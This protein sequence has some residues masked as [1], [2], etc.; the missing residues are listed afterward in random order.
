MMYEFEEG[1]Q[2]AHE[3]GLQAIELGGI[4]LWPK[5]KGYC[6]VD[7]LLADRGE[8]ERWLDAFA[9][10][11]LEISALSG[12]GA[13]LTP[14]KEAAQE[15]SRQFRRQCKLAELAGITRM[16]LLAGLPEGAEGDTAPNW[17]TFARVAFLARH[18]RVAVGE[19][20]D[21]V[22]A[23]ARQDRSGSWGY[24]LLRD[25]RRRHDPQPGDADEIAPGD[26]PRRCLQLRYFPPMWY[27]GI[28]PIEAV[29]YLGPLV[30]HVHAK[31]TL[32]HHHHARV[33]GLMD[34]S[35][36]EHPEERA[37]TYT[38]VGWGHGEVTWREFVA[39]LRLIGYDHVISLE[40]ECEYI[41]VKEGLEKSVGFFKPI[42]L[43]KR[44]VAK[45]VGAGRHGKGPAASRVAR[46][47]ADI[48]SVHLEWV[49]HA[50]FRLWED[51]GP[52]IAMDP[53][54][55]SVVAAAVGLADPT[56]L[57]IRLQA[58]TVIVSS[59]TDAAALLLQAC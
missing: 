58:D 30:Q 18:P 2:Y 39:T 31:D 19:A 10:H 53:Y 57:D 50:C 6:E 5:G 59:L 38:L 21:P 25:A 42:L 24:A 9:R 49:G 8:I 26:R 51:G 32:I 37:W 54:T 55:P 3:L 13:P 56:E 43:E 23:E 44:P 45:W 47:E 16:T 48:M 22:L 34:S 35:T 14:D 52:V 29:R 11:D 33:R 27:Q 17:V 40:M 41:D 36:T 46:R 20:P 15:Y 28:D 7:R 1:L 4:G 12:H